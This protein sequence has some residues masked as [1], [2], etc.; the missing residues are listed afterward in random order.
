MWKMLTTPAILNV[1]VL[2][3]APQIYCYNWISPMGPLTLAISTLTAF[4]LVK[5]TQKAV[6]DGAWDQ[7]FFLM[8]K[9]SIYLFLAHFLGFYSFITV[10]SPIIFKL[11]VIIKHLQTL[12]CFFLETID[13]MYLIPATSLTLTGA[14]CWLKVVR[15]CL[16]VNCAHTACH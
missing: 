7:R 13:N 4:I 6:V 10:G 3:E 5:L 2:T 8:T 12:E 16:C 9:K 1:I 15:L 14:V 11:L